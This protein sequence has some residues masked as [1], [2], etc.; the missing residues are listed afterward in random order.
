MSFYIIIEFEV[1]PLYILLGSQL[2][3]FNVT[4][5]LK[6]LRRERKGKTKR[7]LSL[8]STPLTFSRGTPC[9]SGQRTS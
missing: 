6:L 4:E 8:D 3:N 5:R 2:R 7:G 1:Y 9:R